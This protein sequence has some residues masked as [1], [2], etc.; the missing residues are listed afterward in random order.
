MVDDRYIAFG[1]SNLGLKSLGEIASDYELN[2]IIDSAALT[3]KTAKVI[4]ED[5]ALSIPIPV[6]SAQT[7]PLGTR[8]TAWAQELTMA[9]IL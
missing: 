7:L 6:E 1:S 8:L 4:E 9:H 5:I 3:A 2:G